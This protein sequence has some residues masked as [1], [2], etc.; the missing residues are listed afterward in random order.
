MASKHVPPAGRSH[1]PAGA[2]ASVAG[3]RWPGPAPLAAPPWRPTTDSADTAGS[4][5][6]TPPPERPRL[7][8]TVERRTRPPP[9]ARPST[10]SASRSRCSSPMWRGRWTGPGPRSGGVGEDHGPVLPVLAEGVRRFGGRSTSSPATGSWRSSAPRS[11]RRTTPG[12]RA[13]PPSTSSSASAAYAEELRRATAS[14]SRACR[15][16][17]RGGG[18]RAGRGDGRRSTPPSATR[19]GWPSG[20]RH[21]PSP[22]RVYL[23]E[24][25]ARLLSGQ[26]RLRDL[27]PSA[28]KGAGEP[29]GVSCPRGRRTPPAG[30]GPLGRTVAAWWAG[31]R[32]WP[33]WKAALA[34]ARAGTAQVVGVVGEPAWAR[35]GSAR[36]SPGR[37]PPGGSPCGGRRACPTPPASRSLPVLELLRDYF[38]IPDADSPAPPGRRSPGGSLAARPRLRDDLPLLFDFLEV[39]DPERPPPPLAAEARSRRVFEVLRRV[40]R[41]RSEQETLVLLL[42]DLHWFDPQ[43][44][45]FLERAHRLYP[46]TRTLVVTNFR[47]EFYAAVGATPTTASSRSA[48]SRADAVGELLGAAPRPRRLARSAGRPGRR[49][50]RA[51]TRSSSRRSSAR[52]SRTGPWP[53]NP[54][55]TGSPARR[56]SV[57]VPATVQATLA[58][59]IDRLA[60]ARQAAAP[61]GGRHRPDL[62]RAGPA[63]VAR[64][65]RGRPRRPG[66]AACARPSSSRRQRPGRRRSTASGTPSPG[67]GLLRPCCPGAGARLHAA[68]AADHRRPDPAGRRAGRP[69][70]LALRPGRAIPSRRPAGRTGRPRGSSA[71]TSATPPGAGRWCS[72]LLDQVRRDRRVPPS[73]VRAR[74]LLVRAYSRLGGVAEQTDT[75][76]GDARLGP[77]SSATRNKLPPRHRGG[78]AWIRCCNDSMRPARGGAGDSPPRPV[79]LH[80]RRP[81]HRP[82][83]A[84]VRRTVG[85]TSLRRRPVRPGTGGG[86]GAAIPTWAP[87]SSS[88]TASSAPSGESG[89]EL[90]GPHGSDRGGPR[91]G[92]ARLEAG[93][94]AGQ[95]GLRAWTRWRPSPCWPTSPVTTP[96]GDALELVRRGRPPD[97][98]GRKHVGGGPWPSMRSPPP[99]FGLGRPERA[100]EVGNGG[101]GRRPE[102]K[103][104]RCPTRCQTSWPVCRRPPRPG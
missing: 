100:V 28:V 104:S 68:V 31:P 18:G 39:P 53:A 80:L 24:H 70:R 41:R 54:A 59:R 79:G 40:T 74:C 20:W 63:A 22:A 37:P 21:W 85:R 33:R 97:H 87:T 50:D 6:T 15:T 71:A 72:R 55:P 38:G 12:G 44:E 19:S 5:W 64:R 45:A 52:W 25:T 46:G 48:R 77:N 27:G 1:R 95:A 3:R 10:G 96:D 51:A 47:P 81:G 17:L 57:R 84:G 76:L 66:C 8:R 11:P 99:S 23:T 83:P 102:K 42:E 13:T 29:V 91:R 86:P 34:R 35:A 32:S 75:L 78:T 62:H 61:D 65:G 16:Q 92:Q 2:S 98:R 88:G 60:D 49:A 36:S 67:G 14:T 103:G 4:R 26:F 90:L 89:G 93:R 43:S 58:A 101:R 82:D 73:G 94:G 69:A 30:P 56:P 9:W 7:A